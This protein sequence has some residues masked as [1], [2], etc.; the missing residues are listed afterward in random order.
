MPLRSQVP[1][2]QFK[3]FN[4]FVQ[5]TMHPI[6]LITS[7]AR[8]SSSN[9]DVGD[10]CGNNEAE[11]SP[12]GYSFPDCFYAYISISY[13]VQ[14]GAFRVFLSE[15][16]EAG[17][18]NTFGTASRMSADTTMA[19][20]NPSRMVFSSV[21]LV[22]SFQCLRKA[23]LHHEQRQGPGVG[24]LLWQLVCLASLLIEA[25]RQLS[26][27]DGELMTNVY[28]IMFFT[29]PCVVEQPHPGRRPSCR[30]P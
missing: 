28:S 17:V 27:V 16:A 12:L 15:S 1:R 8:A 19:F 3:L 9:T 20:C 2:I 5:A 11:S 6:G 18:R 13:V 4:H 25:C 14:A 24:S 23:R 26:I 21:H 7:R 30:S 10:R 29:C 22:R